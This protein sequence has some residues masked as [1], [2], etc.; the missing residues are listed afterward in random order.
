VPASRR[1]DNT[2]RRCGMRAARCH[3]RIGD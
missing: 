2:N 3:D 1:A